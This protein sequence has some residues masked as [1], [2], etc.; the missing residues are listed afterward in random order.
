MMMMMI[1][2]IKQRRT[3][4]DKYLKCLLFRH[5]TDVKFTF[6][7]ISDKHF[8]GDNRNLDAWPS[9]WEEQDQQRRDD[10]EENAVLKASTEWDK[11]RHKPR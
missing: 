5:K 9:P 11:E 7:I 1:I 8:C 2:I 10:S 3:C 4:T 6:A